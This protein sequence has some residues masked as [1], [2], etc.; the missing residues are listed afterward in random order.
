MINPNL[1][2]TK[3]DLLH[4]AVDVNRLR[5]YKTLSDEDTRVDNILTIYNKFVKAVLGE[6]NMAPES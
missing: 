5:D 2:A 6:E 4:L 1:L 3:L